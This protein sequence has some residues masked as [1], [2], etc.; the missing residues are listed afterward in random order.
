MSE[1]KEI[2]VTL[3]P[4]SDTKTNWET[5]N[6]TLEKNEIGI[7]TTSHNFKVGDGTTKWNSLPYYITKTTATTTADGLMSKGDKTKLDGIAENAT[8]VIESTVSGWGFTKNT[9]TVTGVKINGTT[10]NPTSGIVD[11]G[12][13]LTS[14]QSI[15]VL[16]TNGGAQEVNP[17]ESITGS[18]MIILHKISK[19]GNYNDLI[20]K[21]DLSVY[22]N[23]DTFNTLEEKVNSLEGSIPTVNNSKITIK[24]N[25]T[26]VDSFTLNQATA[27]SINITVPTKTSDLTNNSNFISGTLT[28]V[29]AS[30]ATL[31]T[32]RLIGNANVGTAVSVIKSIDSTTQFVTGINGGGGSL[33]VETEPSTSN[34]PF[35][36]SVTYTALTLTKADDTFI[37]TISG[38]SGSLTSNTTSTSGIKYIESA[39]YTSAKASG[40]SS[41]GISSGSASLSG[42]YTESSQKLK[43]T[44]SYTAQ[45]LTG[46]T[47]FVTGITP[48][49]FTP[50]TKYLHHT[51]TGASS[52]TTGKA[53]TS[54]TPSGGTVNPTTKFLH[55][56]HTG[57]LV[58]AQSKVS[59]TTV[60]INPA[61][62]STDKITPATFTDVTA[63]KIS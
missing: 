41:V 60:S 52:A 49:T 46:T 34:I 25:G 6:Y 16:N 8:R 45:Q 55:H 19:T 44:L 35:V 63:T 20:G 21:P 22:V 2:K 13:V 54:V 59:S 42:T 17:S 29:T 12:T 5:K 51:H 30:K 31:G 33:T 26:E 15:K 7:D 14:H 40:T 9:G 43:I 23:T 62:T 50:T 53:L 3:C 37:K 57:A 24:K 18:G 48:G 61:T 36:E 27:K 4:R 39:T 11:L 28:N 38:G 1:I 10:K 47:T 56:T 58:N 32:A